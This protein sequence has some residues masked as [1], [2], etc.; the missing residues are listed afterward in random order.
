MNQPLTPLLR[1]AALRRI[2]ADHSGRALMEK[3]GNAAAETVLRLQRELA[4]P[5]LILAGPGNN[6]GDAFVLAR[7]LREKGLA[8]VVVSRF[9]PDRA[10][11]D[12]R[13]AWQAWRQEGGEI[14]GEVPTAKFGLLVDG[15]F[16]IGLSRPLDGIYA[17]WVEAANAYAGP[18]LALDVP[19]GLDADSGI[20]R[21]PTVR[22]DHTLTFIAAKPGLYTQDGPDHCGHV[23]V[24]DLGLAQ[25]VA[26]AA[27][28]RLLDPENGHAIFPQVLF[29]RRRNSHK[30]SYGSIG[31]IGGAPGMAGAVLL[32]GRAAL[33]F[34]AGKVHVGMLQPLPLDPLQPELMLR[35]ASQVLGL[36]TVLAVGPGL[37]DSGEAV[38]LLRRAVAEDKPLVLDADGLNLLAVHPVLG[39]HLSRR[40]APVLLTPH[41]LEAARLLGSD[42]DAVQRDRI[43]AAQALARRYQAGVV[44]KGDG[45]ILA[46]PDG[47]WAVNATGNPGLA[48]AGSGDVLTG[49][50]AALLAQKV[51][52]F[53]ALAA[54]VHLHGLAAER[55]ALLGDGPKGLTAS[56]LLD[57]ARAL[58]NQW[59]T[60]AS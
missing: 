40:S 55:C 27:P 42:V 56:E 13:H 35:P 43:A 59:S 57:P 15:L 39:Q 47:A 20:A 22:A 53:Q 38:D 28:G 19:S 8:P 52:P 45:S 4:G 29:P 9:D 5:P 46:E 54:A 31:I 36:A 26:A 25:A 49:F 24:A 14:H 44:L 34:G 7:V 48:T 16:G 1:S 2:E 21:G 37:G 3:A 60:Q 17:D 32:A 51:P 6:G 18:V 23:G 50:V 30:G 12:A 11:A 58:L 33:R 41:P 10:P